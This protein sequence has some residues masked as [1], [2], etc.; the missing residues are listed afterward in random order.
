MRARPLAGLL[1]LVAPVAAG[2]VDVGAE[3][4]AGVE[5]VTVTVV[6]STSARTRCGGG[7]RRRRS[8]ASGRVAD[9]HLAVVV[10]VVVAEAVVAFAVW[11]FG[12]AR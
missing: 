1:L 5:V 4:L 12:V 10:D 9:A 8:D 11:G 7:G 3:Y 2:R 6:V